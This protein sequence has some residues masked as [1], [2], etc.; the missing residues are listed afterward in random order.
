MDF[1]IHYTDQQQRFREALRAWLDDNVPKDLDIPPDGRPLDKETQQRVRDFRRKLGE[2]GWLAPSWPLEW[3]GGGLHPALEAV[4]LEEI[5]RL[6][7]PSI[8]NTQR[9]IP[10]LLV[11]GS[12]EQKERYVP[13][14]LRGET[15]V[16]Q[17]F[18]EWETGS[19]LASI[20]THAVRDGGE[21]VIN[22]SKAFVLGRFDP[23][24]LWTLAVTDVTRPAKLNLGV[25]MIDAS[26]PGISI[27]TQDLLMGSDSHIELDEVRAPADCL[28]GHQY[29]GWEI[30]QATVG[31]EGGTYMLV[32]GDDETVRSVQEFLRQQNRDQT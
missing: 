10:P 28:I 8:G 15:I 27:T 7:L 32:R 21:W 23:D 13:P 17:L 19:D 3:G 4:F 22:G 12:P 26:S 30:S 9:W 11:W 31:G 18:S 6:N 14:A 16:W 1:E 25:F 20:K 24:F 5:R 2:K 29:Q